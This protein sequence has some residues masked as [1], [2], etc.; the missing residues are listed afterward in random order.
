MSDVRCRMSDVRYRMSDI[1]GTRQKP[2]RSG[3]TASS[4]LTAAACPRYV[5]PRAAAHAVQLL[6]QVVERVVAPRQVELR[7]LHY[8]QRSRRV[9]EEEM[10]V[11]LVQLADVVV[12][13]QRSLGIRA[14]TV[15][16]A[17]A[18]HVRRRLEEDHEIGRR[19]ILREQLVDT[20]IDEQLVVVEIQVR[21]NLVALEQ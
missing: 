13:E 4:L 12:V 8:E 20:L 11:R 6:H 1:G 5:I 10:V 18:K 14:R 21:V 2:P 9:V 15:A 7:R 17:F 3:G 19:D 16:Q